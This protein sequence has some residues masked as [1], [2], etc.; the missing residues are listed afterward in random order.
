[1]KSALVVGGSGLVGSHCLEELLLLP[2][3]GSVKA[4]VRR[5]LGREHPR[6]EQVESDF[7]ELD[8][9]AERLAAEEVF[10]CLGTTLRKAGSR[11]AFR[12]VDFELPLR[13]AQLVRA[14]GASEFVLVS[15]LGADPAS[16]S[17]YLRVKGELEE[18]VSR[19]GFESLIIMRPSLLRGHRAEWRFGETAAKVLLTGLSPLLR[20][21]FRRYRPIRARTVARAMINMANLGLYGRH[22]VES[23]AM[24]DLAR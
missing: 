23:E 4:L 22:V 20:G 16:S 8:A 18:A 13:I 7:A 12:R 15:S 17:F 9:V 21:S 2:Q 24:A 6:L 19:L 14:Q 1:M 11:D 10:C 3:Y 5:P